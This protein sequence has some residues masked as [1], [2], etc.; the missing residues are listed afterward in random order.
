MDDEQHDEL[1]PLENP[2][3]NP[4]QTRFKDILRRVVYATNNIYFDGVRDTEDSGSVLCNVWTL[5]ADGGEWMSWYQ[6]DKLYLRELT[7]EAL[8]NMAH[9]VLTA[10]RDGRDLGGGK[11]G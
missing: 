4:E 9:N 2:D 11:V 6:I 7:D 3:W 10:V 1:Y 8:Y 5:R